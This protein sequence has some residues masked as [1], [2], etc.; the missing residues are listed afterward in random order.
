MSLASPF[1]LRH[2]SKTNSLLL[3][4]AAPLP[5]TR[6]CFLRSSFSAGIRARS[7]SMYWQPHAVSCASK[8]T[9]FNKPLYIGLNLSPEVTFYFELSIKNVSNLTNLFLTKILDSS[10]RINASGGQDALA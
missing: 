1:F 6:H 8:T 4:D 3:T 10:A 2:A 9:D 5:S 7:L